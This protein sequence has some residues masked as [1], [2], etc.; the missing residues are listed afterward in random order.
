MENLA[1]HFD[2]GGDL[3]VFDGLEFDVLYNSPVGVPAYR[4]I[5]AN[6]DG[7]PDGG[8]FNGVNQ[9][10]I[11]VIKFCQNLRQRMGPARF[12]LADAQEPTNQRAFGILNGVESEG[13]PVLTDLDIQDWSGG[14]NRLSF[15]AAN[16]LS[17]AW[18]YINHKFTTP[19]A[20]GPGVITQVP[21]STDRL[22]FA[23]AM[24]LNAAVC[25]SLEPTAETG[26]TV[27]IWD[28][29]DMGTAHK[30]GWL[31]QPLGPPQRLALQ[32]A[33]LLAGNWRSLVQGKGMTIAA[34]GNSLKISPA[35]PNAT[36]IQF[37]IQNVSTPAPD[38][39]LIVRAH[40]EARS[41]YLSE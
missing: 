1:Q 10:G 5:D 27:G 33:D 37:Q 36:E 16:S 28:E 12:I 7:Q 4:N 26:Q 18:N 35:D 9:F 29:L 2:K 41:G 30:A 40:A 23:V 32:Q 17:P 25:Y 20:A 15:W 11:G 6:G 38:L 8:I 19:Q 31:G 21:F 22:V 34:D 3:Q 13:W 24:M 14:I 39:L